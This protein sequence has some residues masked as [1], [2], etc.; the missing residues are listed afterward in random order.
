MSDSTLLEK[1]CRDAVVIDVDFT[2]WNN[3][4]TLVGVACSASMVKGRSQRIFVIEFHSAR[5]F[6]CTFNHF[7]AKRKFK[8]NFEWRI[9]R[10]KLL[11]NG[12]TYTATF[13][14]SRDFPRLTISFQKLKIREIEPRFLD[15]HFPGWSRSGSG[16]A[17]IT[18]GK[19]LSKNGSRQK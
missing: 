4:I 15:Q 11:R 10:L 17:A 16:L 19:V 6:R 8:V 5:E 13:H 18:I 3:K 1:I 7:A 12:R 2:D 14:Q 9:D